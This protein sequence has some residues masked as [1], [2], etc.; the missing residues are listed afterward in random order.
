LP[1][2]AIIAAENPS[3]D[4]A[5]LLADDLDELQPLMKVPHDYAVRRDAASL[6]AAMKEMLRFGSHILFVDPFYDP[7]N[8]RYKNTFRE[9]FRLIGSLNPDASC[10]IHYR[11]HEG[12]PVRRQ[13][14]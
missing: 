10:E 4:H 12:R 1:F 9:C 14:I 2:H 3:G 11:H 8:T 6:S 13:I 7:F 5:V